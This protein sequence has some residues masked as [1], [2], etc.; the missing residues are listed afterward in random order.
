MASKK[1]PI[2]PVS[3]RALIQR[4]NRKL[5]DEDQ[6]VKVTRGDRAKQAIGRHH[7]LHARL[8][9][10]VHKDID[11]EDWGRKLGALQPWEKLEDSK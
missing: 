6:M 5:S 4:L 8:N 1:K 10:I 7:I 2:V 9:F 3:E 11:L